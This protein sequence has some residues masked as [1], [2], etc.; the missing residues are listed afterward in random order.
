MPVE[1]Q[2]CG[3]PVIAFGRG[4]V[5][6]TVIPANSNNWDMATGILFSEQTVESLIGAIRQFE[7]W[8]ESSGL[9]CSGTMLSHLVKKDLK[10]RYPVLYPKN[11]NSIL[12]SLNMRRVSGEFL[13][14]KRQQRTRRE[15]YANAEDLVCSTAR[16]GKLQHQIPDPL[17]H[18]GHLSSSG[19]SQP[20]LDQV[21]NG[22][23]SSGICLS[24]Q[25]CHPGRCSCCC[26]DRSVERQDADPSSGLYPPVFFHHLR[27]YFRLIGAS[28]DHCLGR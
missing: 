24:S 5:E 1:A 13:R 7:Q 25:V 8:E 14:H 27:N 9:M 6:D 28:P 10:S 18:D 21:C 20:H 17:V 11:G 2:A 22:S 12:Q 19:H 26:P 23:S 3:T 4:G 16:G 15:I